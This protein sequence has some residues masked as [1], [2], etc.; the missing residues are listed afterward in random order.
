MRKMQPSGIFAKGAE[1]EVR[2]TVFQGKPALS[3]KRLRKHYRVAGLDSALR[4]RR[5]RREAKALRVARENGVPCPELFLENDEKNEL[6]IE[7]LEGVLLSRKKSSCGEARQA[8][9]VLARLHYAGI[10]HGDFSTSNLMSVRGKVFVIDFGL[11]EFSRELEQRADDAIVFEKSVENAELAQCFRRG[12]AARAPDAP[13]VF[14]RMK[15]ILSRA[16]YSRS[17]A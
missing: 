12:Y 17:V 6:V 3:K 14:E 13:K 16:R 10:A 2:E 11:S 15:Q 4:S 9:E 8:G 1:A 7:R 5:T